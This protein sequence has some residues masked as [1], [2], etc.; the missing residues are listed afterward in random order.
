LIVL[1]IINIFVTLIITMTNEKFSTYSF[2]LERTARRI[3][4]YAQQR[5][6]SENFDITVDQWLVI[7][8]LRNSN[9]LN[10]SELAE[11]T[12]KDCP[13]LTRIIDLLCKKELTERRMD[14]N[15]RRSFIIHLTKKGEDAVSNWSPKV[16]EIRMKAWENLTEDDYE[17]LKRILNTI[18]NNLNVLNTPIE[19]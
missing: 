10:Q 19:I 11:L 9:D 16:A 18:Y 17:N 4:Q 2:L 15:D 13:T 1:N 8:N 7:K 14:A 3:K 5:F 6:N 12:G